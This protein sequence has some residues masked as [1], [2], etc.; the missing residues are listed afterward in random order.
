MFQPEVTASYITTDTTH[1]L[2]DLPEDLL[3][4]KRAPLSKHV[5]HH[6]TDLWSCPDNQP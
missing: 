3:S 6:G 5:L 4:Q 1:T 2:R